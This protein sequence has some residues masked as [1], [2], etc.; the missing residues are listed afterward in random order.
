MARGISTVSGYGAGG[1]KVKIFLQNIRPGMSPYNGK[2]KFIQRLRD[3]LLT[4]GDIEIVDNI[5]R[6]DIHFAMNAYTVFGHCKRVVRLDGYKFTCTKEE[7]IQADKDR[8]RL[9][10]V[11]S[12]GVVFQSRRSKSILEEYIG[13]RCVGSAGYKVIPNG[14]PPS[15][16]RPTIDPKR[17]KKYYLMACQVLHSIRNVDKLLEAWSEIYTDKKLVIVYDHTRSMVDIDFK[18]YRNVE[19]MNILMPDDLNNMI[20]GAVGVINLTTG[21]NCPNLLIESLA[22][23]TPFI[24]SHDNGIWEYVTTD[25]GL[26]V[27]VGSAESIINAIT[28][29]ERLGVVV[30]PYFLTIEHVAYRYI[31]YFKEVL[32]DNRKQGV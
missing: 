1:D 14:V 13:K 31:Q 15:E 7:D 6:C 30:L 19:T 25:S 20:Y 16:F 21:D 27:D 32:N 2:G 9:T 3:E 11:E 12:D 29:I 5:A 18:K 8:F 28:E 4:R 22:I 23:G 10:F 24:A 17:H 26:P